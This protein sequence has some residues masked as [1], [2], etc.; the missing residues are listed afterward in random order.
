MS[1]D[2]APLL[3][4]DI[5][6]LLRLVCQT[7]IAELSLERGDARIHLKRVINAAPMASATTARSG[8]SSEA[9]HTVP[10]LGDEI[11]N[12]MDGYHITSP[13]V[14]TFYAAP[15]PND[16]PYVKVGDQV[17]PGDVVGIVEAMKMMNEIECDIHGYV[18]AV[19]IENG[20][21][22]EYGQLLI[23]ITPEEA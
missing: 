13:M 6:E 16:P 23:T 4:D 3:T 7:D 17:F 18:A 8:A 15:S 9:I 1:D 22:V 10:L 5:R 19:H 21:A 14:G 11:T 12:D 2:Q 20:H